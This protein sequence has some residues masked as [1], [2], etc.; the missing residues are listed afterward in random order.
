MEDD[1]RFPF[2]VSDLKQ[3]V[4]CQRILYYHYCLP[5]IRPTTYKMEEGV[6]AGVA[7]EEREVRRTLRPYGLICGN[8]KFHVPL[9]SERLG[10]RGE[11][12]LVIETHQDGIRELIPVDYK[13][14]K[15]IG[16]HFK[17]QLAA[18]AFL[19]EEVEGVPVRRGFLYLI[20]MRRAEQVA[21]DERL[22]TQLT[23]ALEGMR[24]MLYRE[25]MPPAVGSPRKCLPCE[26]HRFCNDVL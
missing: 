16:L 26:F 3:W 21:I 10:L 13:D 9:T 18:Y 17:L 4:Y 22:R 12:D 2:R 19:L 11:L 23:E 7:E 1:I 25:K 8:R 24:T 15:R 5:A 14:S 20:P 6:K